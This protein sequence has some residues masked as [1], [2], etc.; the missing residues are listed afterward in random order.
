MGEHLHGGQSG[1]R[2]YLLT[3]TALYGGSLVFAL[4]GPQSVVLFAPLGLTIPMAWLRARVP[5]SMA[6]DGRGVQQRRSPGDVGF[7][8]F[9]MLLHAAMLAVGAAFL[10]HDHWVGK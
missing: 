3:A 10:L 1:L 7:A 9:V 6:A 8:R 5:G 2:L 4:V